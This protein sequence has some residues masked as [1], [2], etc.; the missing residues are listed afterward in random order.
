MFLIF[1]LGFTF[2]IRKQTT[3]FSRNFDIYYLDLFI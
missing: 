1:L 2:T 3:H